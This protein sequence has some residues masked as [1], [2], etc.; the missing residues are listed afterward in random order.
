M[1]VQETLTFSPQP[2]GV[3]VEHWLCDIRGIDRHIDVIRD[4]VKSGEWQAL[5]IEV[6][7]DQVGVMVWSVEI[8]PRGAVIVVN[9]LSGHA[10]EHDLTA[11]ALT[12]LKTTGRAVGAVALRFW[13]ERRGLVRKCEKHG[14]RAS[15]VMEGQ[16]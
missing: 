11:A 13:T 6:G 14:M 15:Y 8:E 2:W 9:A 16:L 10:P 1:A 4:K 3:C 5:L 7:G 12:F